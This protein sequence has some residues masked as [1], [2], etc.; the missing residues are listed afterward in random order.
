MR[1]A[2]R[3]SM[4]PES[5]CCKNSYLIGTGRTTQATRMSDVGKTYLSAGAP[6]IGQLVQPQA[7]PEV[8]P[9][10]A[11]TRRCIVAG[12]VSRIGLLVGG[13]CNDLFGPGRALRQRRPLCGPRP[14][15]SGLAPVD[16]ARPPFRSRGWRNSLLL[17]NVGLVLQPGAR[18]W[19][20]LSRS[21]VQS[22]A[23]VLSRAVSSSRACGPGGACRAR[24]AQRDSSTAVASSGIRPP[25]GRSSA[26]GS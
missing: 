19:F 23:G 2:T 13:K 22:R 9:W 20:V 8:L 14:W 12:C 5:G 21:S 4:R 1:A 17:G 16:P 18:G 26:L 25:T 24:P 3:R 10:P 15:A 11:A 7:A 6:S